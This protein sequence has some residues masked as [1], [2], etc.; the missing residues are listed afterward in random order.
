MKMVTLEDTFVCPFCDTSR[1][2]K[3]QIDFHLKYGH[4]DVYPLMSK[5]VNKVDL[6]AKLVRLI[7]KKKELED[8][9][10]H[11]KTIIGMKPKEQ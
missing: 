5:G 7:E 10:E 4:A 3:R 11:I 8:D 2:S 6:E 1:E 9:I